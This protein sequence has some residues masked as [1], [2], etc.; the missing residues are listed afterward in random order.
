[1]KCRICIGHEDNPVRRVQVDG[2]T[3]RRRIDVADD[4][5]DFPILHDLKAEGA[6]DYFAL[7]LKSSFGTNY[8]VTYVTDRTGGFT[9]TRN[10]RSDARVATPGAAGRF[11][12]PAAHR[13]QHP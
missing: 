5:L 10:R 9:R 7:P 4:V 1:M 11:A 13:Q 3:V 12:Q 6:T 8:M 2:E